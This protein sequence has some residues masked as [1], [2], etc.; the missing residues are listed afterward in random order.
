MNRKGRIA[1]LEAAAGIDGSPQQECPRCNGRGWHYPLDGEHAAW[2][3]QDR[4]GR[5]LA[6]LRGTAHT[7]Q[8]EPA[9][10]LIRCRLCFNTGSVSE[11]RAAR[12]SA[13][14]DRYRTRTVEEQLAEVAARVPYIPDAFAAISRD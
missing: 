1:K 9:E 6:E 7:P 12:L 4:M 14:F 8:P 13:R 2:Q 11:L 3:A 5:V 10:Q